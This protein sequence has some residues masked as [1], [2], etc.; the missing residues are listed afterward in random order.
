MIRLPAAI[1][2]FIAVVRSASPVEQLIGLSDTLSSIIPELNASLRATL[3][4][5]HGSRCV[6]KI[7]HQGEVRGRLSAIVSEYIGADREQSILTKFLVELDSGQ[8]IET[9][10][11]DLSSI[12]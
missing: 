4:A 1:P 2:N 12:G 7:K 5:L 8:I 3:R 10:G 9:F 11:S 6:I